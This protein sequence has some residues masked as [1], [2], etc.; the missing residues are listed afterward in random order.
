MASSSSFKGN[1]SPYIISKSLNP[2]VRIV[3]L[4]LL[5][6]FVHDLAAENNDNTEFILK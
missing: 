1:I 5:E 4:G 2:D 3:C 6:M